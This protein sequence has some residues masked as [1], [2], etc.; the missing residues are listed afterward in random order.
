MPRAFDRGIPEVDKNPLISATSWGDPDSVIGEAAYGAGTRIQTF[1]FSLFE[2]CGEF[3]T[4]LA[5][6]GSTFLTEL[7]DTLTAELQTAMSALEIDVD[8]VGELQEKIDAIQLQ[9]ASPNPLVT[10]GAGLQA[11]IDSIWRLFNCPD[12]EQIFDALTPDGLAATLED[13]VADLT[14]NPFVQGL[15]ALADFLGD[16]VGNFIRDAI[17]GGGRL[18]EILCGVF[19]CNPTAA[20]QAAGIA[21]HDSGIS[22]TTPFSLIAG[23]LEVLQPIL[24]SPFVQGLVAVAEWLG[25]ET[26]NFARDVF[27]GAIGVADWICAFLTCQ[28]LAT[29]DWPEI[30]TGV[31][32]PLGLLKGFAD[33]VAPIIAN[34]FVQGVIAYA[35]D[36]GVAVGDFFLDL[37]NGA[38]AFVEALCSL[39][40]GGTLPEVFGNWTNTP[41]QIIGDVLG[42]VNQLLDNPITNGLRDLIT[43]DGNLLYDT[44]GGALEFINRLA[45]LFGDGLTPQEITDFLQDAVN[46]VWELITGGIAGAAK[47]LQD[48]IEALTE[49]I[50]KI[51]LIGP[52]VGYLTQG[53]P[54]IEFTPDFAGLAQWADRLLHNGSSIPAGNLIGEIPEAMLSLIPVA[55]IN[56]QSVNLL[57]QGAFATADTIAAADGWSWDAT[58]NDPDNATSKG[59][60]KLTTSGAARALYARQAIKVAAGDKIKLSA[61]VRTAS[62]TGTSSSIVLSVIPYIGTTAQPEVIFATRG[63][64]N[65]A[66]VTL[67]GTADNRNPWTVPANVTSLITKI[68]VTSASGSGS[69]VWFDNIDM[70]KEGLLGQTLVDSLVAAWNEIWRGL[71]NP[72]LPIV[73]GKTWEDLFGAASG[74]RSVFNTEQDRGNTL[75]LNIFGSPTTVGTQANLGFIPNIPRTKSPDMQSIINGIWRGFGSNDTDNRAAEDVYAAAYQ[76]AD[77]VAKLKAS[78]AKLEAD[79]ANNSFSGNAV[80]VDFST[81]SAASS[82]PNP[83]WTST[84]SGIGSGRVGIA[85]GRAAWLGANNDNR[86]DILIYNQ[87]G[88][89]TN[90]QRVSA[91]F[92]TSFSAYQGS[93]AN[94]LYARSNSTGTTAVVAKFMPYACELWAVTNN[95]AT[96]LAVVEGTSGAGF[97]NYN[98]WFW[99]GTYSLECGVGANPRRFRVWADNRVV[100]DHTD[101][102]NVSS[103]GNTADSNAATGLRLTGFG[104]QAGTYV[105]SGTKQALPAELAAFAFYDNTSAPNLGSG[106]RAIK[107]SG[108]NS[109]A[110]THGAGATPAA[111]LLPDSFFNIEDAKTDDLTHDSLTNKITVTVSGWYLVT[112][113]LKTSADIINGSLSAALYKNNSLYSIGHTQFGLATGGG[114]VASET[115]IV[116]LAKDDYVQPGYSANRSHSLIGT[117]NGSAAWS[118]AFLSN[119]KPVNPSST[120]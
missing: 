73:T 18:I 13:I 83:P 47:T 65:G 44:I 99:T 91:V 90:Y 115:F 120:T 77:N 28:P 33:R 119:T 61:R 59:S 52:L 104:S 81:Y 79:A 25:R 112:V 36:V 72:L 76:T 109:V 78:V 92:G 49:W 67:T 86:T 63:A 17:I 87:L 5:E 96:R 71:T 48:I 75:R 38:L 69:T 42:I 93:V 9:L 14:G 46:T 88:T 103:L 68:G 23:I 34:P 7:L 4:G 102:A 6:F 117:T 108:S 57:G 24:T 54:D 43:G 10:I 66:W 26:G 40:T 60:A 114:D 89:K 53:I 19:T 55:N 8:L 45:G 82:L 70:R 116:Y 32:T 85:A 15:V 39:I 30:P 56:I 11:F 97:L 1:L 37:F 111:A 105:Q 80:S 3:V 98:F 22:G 113:T 110:A 62:Y 118:V 12:P 50:T 41:A 107:T 101:T 21:A 64:S 74:F 84:R 94:Y 29:G 95:N 106:F 58:V 20:L 27:E 2:G 100:I 35:Q 16:S 31:T 51:P